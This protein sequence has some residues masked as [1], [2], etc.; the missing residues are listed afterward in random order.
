MKFGLNKVKLVSLSVVN[1]VSTNKGVDK[2]S[3]SWSKIPEDKYLVHMSNSHM[4][5]DLINP[6][7]CL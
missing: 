7:V 1:S 5:N 6:L 3:Q 2:I 4:Y